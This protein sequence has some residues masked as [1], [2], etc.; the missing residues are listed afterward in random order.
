MA[1][2]LDNAF[3]APCLQ[4]LESLQH[5]LIKAEAHCTEHSL[6][7]E[8]LTQACLAPDMWPFAKQVFETG[9]HSAGAIVGVRAGVFRPDPDPVPSDFQALHDEVAASI[10]FLRAVPAGELDAIA[11]RDMHFELG[12]AGLNFTVEDFLLSFSLQN[13]FFHTTTAYAILRHLGLAVGKRD[14]I[15]KVRIKQ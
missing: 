11:G 9:H 7:A 1:V 3:I 6:P 12:P 15:G 14:F 4:A 8:T 10:A 2:S 5:M 13:F